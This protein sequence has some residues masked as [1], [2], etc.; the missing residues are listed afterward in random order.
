MEEA[1]GRGTQLFFKG[2]A[3]E[4]TW[5]LTASVM[6]TAAL[7]LAGCGG[8]GGG[9]DSP[10]PPASLVVTGTAATGAALASAAVTVKCAAGGGSTTAGADGR[11]SIDLG[12][13]IT[14]PCVLQAASSST[15]LHGALAAG[16]VANVTPLTELGLA[17]AAGG[18]AASLYDNFD[19]T[20]Q[21]RVNAA[22]LAAALEAL[23]S[24]LQGRVDIATTDPFSVTFAVGDAHDQQLD[25]LTASL[26]KAGMDLPGLAAALVASGTTPGSVATFLQPAAAAC[27]GLR[28]G[29]YRL[30]DPNVTDASATLATV[31]AEA[32]GLTLPGSTAAVP[33]TD[34]RFCSFSF[35]DVSGNSRLLVSPSGLSVLLRQRSG[36]A[37]AQTDVSLLVPEQT[38]PV[39]ELAGT[40][41]VMKYSR[42]DPDQPLVA[43]L[44]SV[45]IA[46]DGTT[47]QVS[48]CKGIVCK[49]DPA[50]LPA[51]WTAH[52][53]GG[54]VLTEDPTW[55]TRAFGFKTVDGHLSLVL[56][57]PSNSGVAAAARQ[58]A[59]A[60]P[61]VGETTAF[62]DFTV[63]TDGYVFV[64]GTGASAVTSAKVSV[65]AV[66]PATQVVTRQRVDG[67]VDQQ[68]QN[69]PLAGTRYRSTNSCTLSGVPANCSGTLTLPLPGTGMAIYQGL[70]PATFLGISVNLP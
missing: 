15:V 24:A 35:P 51:P 45:S 42:E 31:D 2:Q 29:R 69:Q 34:T 38:L 4:L 36:S 56:R 70:A 19:A 67:R 59:L 64:G 39:S 16:T 1:A 7:A 44:S 17:R 33:L 41:N 14:L 23:R 22:G 60:L 58:E 65:T 61:A 32:L 37:T 12:T 52:P 50:T 30:V 8:G 48:T 40:W 18:T 57:L 55:Q 20:A 13:A 28:S 53:D 47:N 62:W 5:K 68:P 3:M 66:D 46:A 9:G 6:G 27:A 10:P 63:D 25:A 26:A 43:Q 21:S 54:F 11:F 49:A